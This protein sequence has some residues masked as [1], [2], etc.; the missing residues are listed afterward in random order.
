MKIL[1]HE[2]VRILAGWRRMVV[3]IPKTPHQIEGNFEAFQG[4]IYRVRPGRVMLT[5]EDTGKAWSIQVPN[6][7]Y[8]KPRVAVIEDLA[9]G[10]RTEVGF[11]EMFAKGLRVSGP[12]YYRSHYWH[13]TG[14]KGRRFFTQL[15]AEDALKYLTGGDSFEEASL[16]SPSS[17]WQHLL[18]SSNEI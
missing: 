16:E 5:L 15:E 18:R 9:Y 11:D 7:G 13:V 2:T 3:L 1:F 8:P 14:L 17:Q 4:M 6:V 12:V 10:V